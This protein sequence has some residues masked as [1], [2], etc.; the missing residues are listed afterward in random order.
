[1]TLVANCTHMAANLCPDLGPPQRLA[2]T[3]VREESRR[4]VGSCVYSRQR[5]GKDMRK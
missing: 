4:L 5:V 1:M 2:V 3:V